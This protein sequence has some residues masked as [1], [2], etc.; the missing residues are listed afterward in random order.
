VLCAVGV[1]T[2]SQNPTALI[3]AN[4]TI[5]LI[6][7]NNIIRLDKLN[8]TAGGSMY[9]FEESCKREGL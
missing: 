1:R 9:Q 5:V 4:V 2:L 3:L 7:F 8:V 6:P